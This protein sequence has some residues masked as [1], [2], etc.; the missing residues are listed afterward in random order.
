MMW[1]VRANDSNYNL[2][3]LYLSLDESDMEAIMILDDRLGAEEIDTF[4][5]NSETIR[6]D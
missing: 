1:D 4:P 5:I 6:V 2:E 3:V